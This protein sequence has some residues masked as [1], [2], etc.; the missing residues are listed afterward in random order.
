MLLYVLLGLLTLGLI[1]VGLTLM[2]MH[3]ALQQV[4]HAQDFQRKGPALY[5]DLSR[6][7]DEIQQTMGGVVNGLKAVGNQVYNLNLLAGNALQ[8]NYPQIQS[9]EDALQTPQILIELRP[10]HSTDGQQQE[11]TY[12][13]PDDMSP[14]MLERF[15][16][17]QAV[18]TAVISSESFPSSRH[19]DMN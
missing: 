15:K 12:I 14:E 8:D 11:S 13:S 5:Q 10:T 4:I 19:P 1:V 17:F 6:Q 2:K 18:Y 7:V 3:Q 9:A 16:A